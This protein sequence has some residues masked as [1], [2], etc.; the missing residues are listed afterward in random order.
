MARYLFCLGE[1]VSFMDLLPGHIA[2]EIGLIRYTFMRN[3]LRSTL[4]AGTE[5]DRA[6]EHLVT[7]W[8]HHCRLL[9]TGTEAYSWADH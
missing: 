8:H 9:A 6:V 3:S 2:L 7:A 4:A 1:V 5:V